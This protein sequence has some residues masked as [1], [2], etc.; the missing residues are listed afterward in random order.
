MNWNRVRS[1]MKR[2][3]NAASGEPDG[4]SPRTSGIKRPGADATRF[5]KFDSL[6]TS[7]SR[8]RRQTARCQFEHPRAGSVLLIVLV[9]VAMLTLAA[10]NFTQ[11]MLTELE[12]TTMYGADVQAREAAD[13]GVE[14]IATILFGEGLTTEKP[15]AAKPGDEWANLDSGRRD[16]ADEIT[17]Y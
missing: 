2:L 11:S 14:Y 3:T 12:A 13:S 1:N 10:Y 6:P 7:R 15:R 4:V 5:T 8:N 9:V 16:G 17:G